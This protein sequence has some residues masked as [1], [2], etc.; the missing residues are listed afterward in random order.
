MRYSAMLQ[1]DWHRYNV[2]R[3]LAK[4]NA[5]PLSEEE[6]DARIAK[7]G[8]L[9]NGSLSGSDSEDES[10]T[11]KEAGAAADGGDQPTENGF[12]TTMDPSTRS[13]FV[14]V[15]MPIQA[16][17]L[18]AGYLAPTTLTDSANL[19]QSYQ[20]YRTVLYNPRTQES[21]IT[22]DLATRL[23][24]LSTLSATKPAKP[25]T[26]LLLSSGHLAFAVFDPRTMQALAHTTKHRYTVRRKQG[27]AQ[28]GNDG[29]KSSVA[30]SAGAG[31]RRYNEQM[32][33][34]EVREVIADYKE[35]IDASELVFVQA[36]GT[37]NQRSIFGYEGAVLKREDERI[38]S[39]P[40]TTK[41]P[42]FSECERC[43]RELRSVKVKIV[44]LDAE[45]AS[46]EAD[47]AKQAAKEER[48]KASEAKPVEKPVKEE[49]KEDH[50]AA[51]A[52]DHISRGKLDLLQKLVATAGADV[53]SP[54][55]F[56]ATNAN[57]TPLHLASSSGRAELVTYLLVSH[58]EYSDPTALNTRKQSAYDVATDKETRNA[59]RRVRSLPGFSD[60]W[61]WDRGHVAEALT[62]EMEEAQKKKEADKK[63]KEQ[64]REREKKEK[65]RL[66]LEEE[67]KKQEAAEAEKARR[68]EAEKKLKQLKLANIPA[69]TA[70]Q[71][72][73]KLATASA[74]RAAGVAAADTLT[75]EARMR[76]E[77]EKR[78]LAAE[79]RART[80]TGKCTFCG[81]A[82]NTL[83][84][85][86]PFERMGW[87]Y[88]SMACLN[89]HREYT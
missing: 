19:V 81:L 8:N 17:Q 46:R 33:R 56:P 52:A 73:Y 1:T 69:S 87:K 51:K 49:K 12:G 36:S 6:F 42:T 9:S 26:F 38:R 25:W 18:P 65:E 77:R 63:A 71:G 22:S 84:G 53:F 58:P 88:C 76:I 79:W 29:G 40:F 11:D 67:K 20:I 68:A 89:G 50:E 5:A 14:V 7:D 39:I 85:T 82:L 41:R 54:A 23:K 80:A 31:L 34:E 21:P 44:D 48:K 70:T 10:D 3:R 72:S 60:R 83:V 47:A 66:R 37:S 35:L 86:Q 62:E 64:E 55:R 4:P 43:A 74:G 30:H 28:S 15:N 57:P 45:R 75:P 13:P 59:F 27:G 16:G 2:K 61:D 32:L 78:A 24:H